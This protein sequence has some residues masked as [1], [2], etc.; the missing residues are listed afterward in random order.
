MTFGQV[1]DQIMG[2]AVDLTIPPVPE[3][4]EPE[5]V[6]PEEPEPTEPETVEPEETEEPDRPEQI[7]ECPDGK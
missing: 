1:A 7:D 4:V 2:Q 6:E 5:P 3:P